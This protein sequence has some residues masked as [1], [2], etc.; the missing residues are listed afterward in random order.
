MWH[1]TWLQYRGPGGGSDHETTMRPCDLEQ[2]D[3]QEDS[4]FSLEADDMCPTKRPRTRGFDRWRWLDEFRVFG[5]D[6]YDGVRFSDD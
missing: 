3:T 4:P 6:P 2:Y 1:V 5:E